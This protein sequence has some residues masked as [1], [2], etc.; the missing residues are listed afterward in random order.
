MDPLVC[1][2]GSLSCPKV[3]PGGSFR[4]PGPRATMTDA[5]RGHRET[6]SSRHCSSWE[7][8]NRG[9]VN[10]DANKLSLYV[11]LTYN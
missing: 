4:G 7:F 10:L 11:S 1:V 8:L 6:V 9:A 5:R 2:R 3:A